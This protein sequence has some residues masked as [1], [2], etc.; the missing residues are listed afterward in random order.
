MEF[1]CR[2]NRLDWVGNPG[3]PVRRGD[4]FELKDK[5]IIKCLTEEGYIEPY[6]EPK[7]EVAQPVVKSGPEVKDNEADDVKLDVEF[8]KPPAKAKEDSTDASVGKSPVK[9]A[10]P[11]IAKT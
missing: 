7:P 10:K 4:R 1:I 5:R 3:E 9:T 11:D 2:M 8:A 6:V